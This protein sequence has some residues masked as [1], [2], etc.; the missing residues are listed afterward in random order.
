VFRYD[1]HTHSRASH[2]C[3]TSYA[4]LIAMTRRRGLAG[5]ALTDHDTMDGYVALRDMWPADMHLIP[6]C[7]RTLFDGVHIIGLFLRETLRSETACDVIEEIHAQGGIVY[8]PHPFREYSGLLGAAAK[9]S[10]ADQQWAAEHCDIIEVYNRKCTADE[11]QRAREFCDQL[12]KNFAGGSD[13]HRALEIGYG[14][15]EFA[16]RLSPTAFT[17]LAAFGLAEE[18]AAAQTAHRDKHRK[19]GPRDLARTLLRNSGLLKPARALRNRWLEKQ[20]PTLIQY[21]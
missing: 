21:R 17:S 12:G 14:V 15:T 19:T 18:Q 11:N 20:Q 3:K 8:L 2:D 9:H 16:E 13:A 10:P 6:G 5:I 7:E 4:D 1:L